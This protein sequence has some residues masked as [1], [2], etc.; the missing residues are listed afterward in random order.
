MAPPNG[1]TYNPGWSGGGFNSLPDIGG[2][3]VGSP[4]VGATGNPGWRVDRR[5]RWIDNGIWMRD[6]WRWGLPIGG[7]F[8]LGWNDPFFDWRFNHWAFQPVGV[9]GVNWVPSPWYGYF[10]LPP[11]LGLGNTTVIN[12]N[13]GGG[14][15]DNR[16][17]GFRDD[18]VTESRIGVGEATDRLAEAFRRNDSRRIR[19]FLPTRGEVEIRSIDRTYRVGAREFTDMFL[20]GANGVRT[21]EYRVTNV[22][23]LDDSRALVEIRH[24]SEDPWGD[25]AVNTQR[26]L[27]VSERTGWTV[28]GF[29]ASP[30]AEYED[31]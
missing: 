4:W 21:R 5:Q 27:L 23:R 18:W 2:G 20:D 26:L 28:R 9:F 15:M 16:W 12:V 31:R 3:R 1:N 29:E 24:V 8:G 17:D 7:G 22:Q 6:G 30:R 10:G 19:D 11:Y 13:Q 25:N 14:W